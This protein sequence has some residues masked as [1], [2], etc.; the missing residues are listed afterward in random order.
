MSVLFACV[1]CDRSRRPSRC[2]GA[3]PPDAR[4]VPR[5]REDSQADACPIGERREDAEILDA[6]RWAVKQTSGASPR[7]AARAQAPHPQGPQA[8]HDGSLRRAERL[9]GQGP[10][11]RIRRLQQ[12]PPRRGRQWAVASSLANGSNAIPFL[13]QLN[14]SRSID[15][16]T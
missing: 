13:L 16:A 15:E 6:L 2:R 3:A 9:T 1:A 7:P 5:L 14:S 8:L 12:W 11:V 10:E 4:S